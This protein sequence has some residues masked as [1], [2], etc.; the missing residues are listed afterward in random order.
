MI[1][2]HPSIWDLLEVCL[3]VTSFAE[4]KKDALKDVII[5]ARG[6]ANCLKLIHKSFQIYRIISGSVLS[7]IKLIGD[8]LDVSFRDFLK[9][10][11]LIRFQLSDG[12]R[13]AAHTESFG[14]AE[15]KIGNIWGTIC[16]DSVV[17]G[18]WPTAF[19]RILGY[20]YSSE[21]KLAQN[22]YIINHKPIH[23]H[24]LSCTG[25]VVDLSKFLEQCTSSTQK[26]SHSND[27]FI[28]CV[29]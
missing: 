8:L 23:V 9:I 18:G 20:S 2:Q 26:C 12:Y 24:N 13:L 28:R 19:C 6:R 29:K 15:I 16:D 4:P 25:S 11:I 14:R 27:V 21:I 10:D 7:L 22:Y 1:R 17:P 5:K 3:S